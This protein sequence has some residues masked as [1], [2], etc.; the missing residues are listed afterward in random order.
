MNEVT[1]KSYTLHTENGAWLAQVVLTSDGA[2]MIISDYGNFNYAWRNIGK[3]GFR[4][5][6]ISLTVDYF[7]SKMYNGISYIANGRKIE[8]AAKRFAEHVLPALKKALQEEI[9]KENQ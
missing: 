3:V 6:I 4:E 9:A 8:Q 1:A 2:L 5:F 7:A